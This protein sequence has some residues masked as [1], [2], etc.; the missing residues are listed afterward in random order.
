MRSVNVLFARLRSNRTLVNHICLARFER[1]LASKD[2]YAAQK[3]LRQKTE[4]LNKKT[5][6]T[7]KRCDKEKPKAPHR[8]ST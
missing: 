4:S 3:R 7:K 1:E 5:I 6:P 8:E 2:V